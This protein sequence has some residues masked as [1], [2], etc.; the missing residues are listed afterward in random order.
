M[1]GPGTDTTAD[2][3][4]GNSFSDQLT[5][6]HQTQ[7]TIGQTGDDKGVPFRSGC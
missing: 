2:A 7:L 1:E 5:P 4:W 6:G 3:A